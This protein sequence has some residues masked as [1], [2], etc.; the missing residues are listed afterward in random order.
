MEKREELTVKSLP[1]LSVWD[2][3]PRGSEGSCFLKT[4]LGCVSGWLSC[5]L[6]Y[7]WVPFFCV[8][9][10]FPSPLT[11]TWILHFLNFRKFAW[12]PFTQ[13]I[14]WLNLWQNWH[15]VPQRR[16]DSLSL[17]SSSSL[18]GPVPCWD[19]LGWRLAGTNLPARK[20]ESPGLPLGA[21]HHRQQIMLCLLLQ[22][23]ILT[24]STLQNNQWQDKQ[25]KVTENRSDGSWST[26]KHQKDTQLS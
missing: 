12:T 23:S 9:S 21:S 18:L 6:N 25:W 22:R 19:S 24:L 10:Y 20:T 4:S 1:L 14:P 15:R 5:L 2:P 26:N 17:S 16:T 7:L 8:W 3:E 13:T 11:P